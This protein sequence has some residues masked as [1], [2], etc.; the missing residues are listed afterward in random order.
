MQH[1][2]TPTCFYQR[3]RIEESSYNALLQKTA[4]VILHQKVTLYCKKAES[5]IFCNHVKKKQNALQVIF[6]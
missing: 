6:Y 5:I 1:K 2:N 3:V 4:K